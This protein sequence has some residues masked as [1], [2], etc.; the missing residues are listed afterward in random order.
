MTPS[1]AGTTG[2]AVPNA[3]T[4]RVMA[5]AWRLPAGSW[6]P[7][8]PMPPP[9]T[10]CAAASASSPCRAT[11]TNDQGGT[12]GRACERLEYPQNK[13]AGERC[14]TR[15]RARFGSPA[16]VLLR[17]DSEVSRRVPA[18]S[19]LCPGV[20]M[21]NGNTKRPIRNALRCLSRLSRLS[22]HKTVGVGRK[23]PATGARV[24][25]GQSIF[26][27]Q[28]VTRQADQAERRAGLAG[29]SWPFNMRV[30]RAPPVGKS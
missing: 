24:G 5:A 15:W 27:R 26:L 1:G 29:P 18:V 17:P 6:S 11:P 9:R 30:I 2:G 3:A 20:N 25:G 16:L 13:R 4:W 22:R 14:G 28:K 19:R 7:A 12:D 8:G 21:Q 23:S 10:G